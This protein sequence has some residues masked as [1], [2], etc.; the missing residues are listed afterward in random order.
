MAY[1]SRH[2]IVCLIVLVGAPV[3]ISG[4]SHSNKDDKPV[5][6]LF[7]VNPSLLSEKITY[8]KYGFSFSPP[9]SCLPLTKEMSEKVLK[10]IEKE[11]AVSDTSFV[12][13]IQFFLDAGQQII[14][15]VSSLPKLNEGQDQIARYESA[16]MGKIGND[17][18]KHGIFSH[19]GFVI[20][21]MRIVTNE[22]VIFKLFVAQKSYDSFQIDYI[23]PL[24]FYKMNEEAIE[25][26]IGSLTKK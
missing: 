22:I 6:L 1:S 20:N 11:Y 25:S 26:S 3:I 9:K 23:V 18:T 2:A 17:K 13:P 21:Q 19:G 16:V 15:V 12:K 14:C 8:E 24:K 4:C 5:E 10:T 7:K